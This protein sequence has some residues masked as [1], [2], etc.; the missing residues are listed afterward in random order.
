MGNNR[1]GKPSLRLPVRPFSIV[2][3]ICVKRLAER[4]RGW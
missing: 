2:R 4:E 1:K 3:L